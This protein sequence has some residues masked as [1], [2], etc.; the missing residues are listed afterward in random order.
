MLQFQGELPS[1]LGGNLDELMRHVGS[2]RSQVLD[3]VIKIYSTLCELGSSSPSPAQ[4]ACSQV[5][6]QQP[7]GD[8]DD[9][10]AP[11]L[12]HP[13]LPEREWASLLPEVGLLRP[14]V[15]LGKGI[16]AYR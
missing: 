6:L 13:A 3:V 5:A 10:C 16:G 11:P 12:P 14:L 9:G 8:L 4:E 1:V 15:L 2:L 7:P